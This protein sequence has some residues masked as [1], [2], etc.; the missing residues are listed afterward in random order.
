MTMN[1]TAL[2]RELPSLDALPPMRVESLEGNVLPFRPGLPS[3]RRRTFSPMPVDYRSFPIYL[4][5]RTA[6]VVPDEA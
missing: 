2:C 1:T 6:C 3:S 4:D 5:P